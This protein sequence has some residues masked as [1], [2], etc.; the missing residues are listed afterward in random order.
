MTRKP[1]LFYGDPHKNWSP[2]Y[3]ACANYSE[4]GHIVVVGDLE[5]EKPLHREICDVFDAG[6]SVHYILGNHDTNG[7]AQYQHLVDD[8]PSGH[9]GG[10]VTPVGGFQ[11]AGLSGV[12]KDRIWRPP[13]DQRYEDRR[14]WLRLNAPKKWR[15]WLPIHMIDS[16]FPEDFKTLKA[17]R[18]D[19]LVSHEGPSSVWKGMGFEV[20]DG[21]A[22]RMGAGLIVH[23][24]HHHAAP[25]VDLPN[26]VSVKS[27]GIAEVWELPAEFLPVP[28]VG[29]RR[30]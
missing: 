23:G 8:H 22:K 3:D 26:G 24:H 6:W 1:I 21:L 20:V 16:I 30:P 28:E 25:L 27:L 13:N 2:L 18:A 7:C 12:F 29:S 9:L 10:K 11:V 4:P 15:D 19:D 17:L 14:E 5:L